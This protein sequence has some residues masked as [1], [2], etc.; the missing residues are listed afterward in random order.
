MEIAGLL[1]MGAIALIVIAVAV[2]FLAATRTNQGRPMK[3]SGRIII[4]LGVVAALSWVLSMSVVT[5]EPLERGVVTSYLTFLNPKGYR[6]T[7]LQPGINWVL[8]FFEKV[9]TYTIAR[10]TYTMSAIA[11]EGQVAGDDSIKARTSDG[12]EIV[13]DASVIFQV[14]PN[15][16]IQI[17]ILWQNRYIEDLVRPTARGIIRDVISQYKVDQVVTSQRVEMTQKI[18]D[19][20]AEKFN[21]NGLTLV[22]FVL[23][24]VSFSEEYAKSVEQKQIAEQQAQQSAYVVEQRRQEANQAIET[25]R[26]SAESV[27]IAAQG[28][29]DA[30]LIQANAEAEALKTLA[31]ALK[32]N[33][34]LIQYLYVTK[35]APNVQVIYLPS[36]QQYLLPLPTVPTATTP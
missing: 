24:N 4:I 7:A 16:V 13:I 3:G 18:S 15:Q 35:L 26:G 17:H 31:A 22:D 32:A 14:D 23:R 2:F 28:D 30:R 29:A 36:G 27:K 21:E 19:G 34:D 25:A 6:E 1:Q 12:Q 5:I 33:P 20:M 10:Q 11:T 9:N 8:P